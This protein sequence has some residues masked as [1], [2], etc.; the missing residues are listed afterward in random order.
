MNKRLI[1]PHTAHITY[2]STLFQTKR[3]QAVYKIII[4]LYLRV[5]TD[6]SVDTP[7]NFETITI[8]CCYAIGAFEVIIWT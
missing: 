8:D 2:M 3:F 1:V 6:Y 5:C 4:A 7:S